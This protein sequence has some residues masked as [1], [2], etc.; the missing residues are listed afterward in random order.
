[1]ANPTRQDTHERLT[2]VASGSVRT[3]TRADP[4][5]RANEALEALRAGRLSGAAVLRPA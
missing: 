1:V 3:E 2:L 5:V 4:L